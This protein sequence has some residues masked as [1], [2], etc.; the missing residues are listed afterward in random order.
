M[1]LSSE[2]RAVLRGRYN[3]AQF[4]VFRDGLQPDGRLIE[5]PST[6]FS[7]CIKS[8][9]L[10]PHARR[11]N[12]KAAVPERRTWLA[13]CRAAGV[14]GSLENTETIAATKVISRLSSCFALKAET[15]H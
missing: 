11:H 10:R 5:P 12:W 4:A 7:L 8:A 1:N 14:L 15:F 13:I 2:D 9:R 3:T 6:I